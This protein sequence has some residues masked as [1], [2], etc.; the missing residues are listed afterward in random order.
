MPLSFGLAPIEFW[1]AYRRSDLL[2]IVRQQ[3]YAP[4]YQVRHLAIHAL[5]RV[6]PRDNRRLLASAIPW[7]L[8]HDPLNLDG[9]LIELRLLDR[10]TPWR[11]HLEAMVAAPSFLTRWAAVELLWERGL[12]PVKPT[13][14]RGAAWTRQL[15][16]ILARDRHPSVRWEAQWR[17]D[18]C[19]ASRANRR[20][21]SW[22]R[23]ALVERLHRGEPEPTYFKL[24]LNVSN[25]L[26]VSG[27]PD[28]DVALVDAIVQHLREH[29]INPGY[30]IDAYW[31]PLIAVRQMRDS[32]S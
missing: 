3:V 21:P 7:Y 32:F 19:R 17:L 5:S 31:K 12:N 9:L 28:Y 25:Y 10:N 20:L 29:P 2:S 14:L 11:S 26:G 16:R 6:G 27:E 22:R 13:N 8:S 4:D 15:L 18:Q 1:H 24:W 30:D 23:R